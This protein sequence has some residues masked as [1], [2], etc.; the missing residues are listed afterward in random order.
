MMQAEMDAS[1]ARLTL[2]QAL[3]RDTL[4]TGWEL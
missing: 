1:E 3:K 4:V 2:L